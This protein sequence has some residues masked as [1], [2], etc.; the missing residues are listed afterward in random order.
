MSIYRQGLAPPHSE[1]PEARLAPRRV[2]RVGASLGAWL[3]LGWVIATD[4]GAS[5]GLLAFF[6]PL[7]WL[8]GHIAGNVVRPGRML[9][10]AAI[11]L[12]LVTGTIVVLPVTASIFGLA[13]ELILP[14]IVVHGLLAFFSLRFASRI[15]GRA[16][17][18]ELARACLGPAV[19]GL[20][21]TIFLAA[22]ALHMFPGT[23]PT[24]AVYRA[25]HALIPL[26]FVLVTGVP[27]VPLCWWFFG[28]RVRREQLAG[29]IDEPGAVEIVE[30]SVELE[31][32]YNARV[33]RIAGAKT[34]LGVMALAV[35]HS[36]VVYGQG[37]HPVE[38]LPSWALAGLLA[39]TVVWLFFRIGATLQFDR[40]AVQGRGLAL[41]LTRRKEYAS[42]ALPIVAWMFILPSLVCAAV[43]YLMVSDASML[44]PNPGRFLHLSLLAFFPAHAFVV[45]LALQFGWD[46]QTRPAES[47]PRF[48]WARSLATLVVAVPAT[49]V[50]SLVVVP[51]WHADVAVIATVGAV[52]V[53]PLLFAAMTAIVR[54]ERRIL[55]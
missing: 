42:V 52:V 51:E 41:M 23:F 54:K 33:A 32:V 1:D 37:G 39:A 50:W 2:A 7:G 11:A 4:A 20:A 55:G 28:R 15:V 25:D 35:A 8:M 48:P 9:R 44:D 43:A 16:S 26:L 49:W 5:L 29:V 40:V 24:G 19:M 46:L 22:T 18:R 10:Y 3:A 6:T 34:L 21:V 17:D 36:L 45:L 53:V 30:V 14:G 13:E 38:I 47:L 12:P 27:H 31:A